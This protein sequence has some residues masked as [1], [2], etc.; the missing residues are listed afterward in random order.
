L[1]RT[2]PSLL[3]AW[4]PATVWL[5]M[6]VGEST[7]YM[8][9]E[10]TESALYG[11]L[12]WLFG[13]INLYDFLIWHHYLRKTGHVIGYAML[14]LLL[15]R[16]FRMTFGGLRIW[17][18]SSAAM[19]WV[20]TFIVASLDEWHQSFIPSRTGTYRDV[21]LDSTAG[22]VALLLLYL[23]VRRAGP[24]EPEPVNQAS[25]DAGA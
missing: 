18:R 14:C 16:G 20:G 15:Y 4:W 22:L 21:I 12:T 19:A 6:I 7:D 25:A 8:S 23:W 9:S 3:R 24:K 2:R 13:Q 17:E 5:I 1:S 11:I 10:H